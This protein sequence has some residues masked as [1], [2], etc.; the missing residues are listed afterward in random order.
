MVK[1]VMYKLFEIS[2]NFRDFHS[3]MVKLVM[4]TIMK[5]INNQLFK[6]INI[7]KF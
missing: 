3:S 4:Y 6:I 7:Y 2:F 1:I 5:Y